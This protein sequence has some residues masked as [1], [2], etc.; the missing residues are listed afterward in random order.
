MFRMFVAAVFTLSLVTFGMSG[1]AAAEPPASKTAVGSW[2]ETVTFP[3]ALGRPPI[4]SLVTIH[5]DGTMTCSDQGAVA[6]LQTHVGCDGLA[7]L[8]GNRER[9]KEK[10]KQQHGGPFNVVS[11]GHLDS[12]FM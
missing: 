8:S 10:T 11:W 6:F 9:E 1:T 2:V 3:A 7:S 12:H 5:D 4:K